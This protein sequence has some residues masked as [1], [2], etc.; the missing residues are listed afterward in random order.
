M[1]DD[2]ETKV[3]QWRIHKLAYPEIEESPLGGWVT[4]ADHLDAVRKLERRI[5]LL[6]ADNAALRQ[7]LKDAGEDAT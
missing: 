3:K 2:V 1:S 5:R 4:H 6:E 7:R